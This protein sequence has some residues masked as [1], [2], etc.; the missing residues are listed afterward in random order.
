MST[1]TR[2]CSTV[3]AFYIYIFHV[4]FN[5]LCCGK[6]RKQSPGTIDFYLIVKRLTMPSIFV[7]N[8]KGCGFVARFAITR[9]PPTTTTIT[10]RRRHPH[11]ANP[12][13]P[14]FSYIHS[15]MAF[16]RYTT[17]I[18]PIKRTALSSSPP[19]P[20]PDSSTPYRLCPLQYNHRDYFDA[21]STCISLSTYINKLLPCH[22]RPIIEHT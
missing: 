3:R 14:P 5:D 20:G 15:P 21:T 16:D 9:P 1:S 10:Q 4:N 8:G 6:K 11:R 2:Q 7:T 17:P 13:T 12:R 22:R 19:Q 18:D